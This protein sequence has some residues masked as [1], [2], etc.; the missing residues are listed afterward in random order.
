MGIFTRFSSNAVRPPSLATQALEPRP[1]IP[2]P[3][4]DLALKR[5]LDELKA[6]ER[7]TTAM[8]AAIDKVQAVIEFRL[9]GTVITANDNFLAAV[10]YSLDE[11]R[12]QHHG[13]FVDPVYRASREY[14]EFWTRL[15]SGKHDAGVYCRLGKGGRA[16]WMQASYN[17][18]F[19]PD[20][21]VQSVVKFATDITRQK[22]H[23]ADVAGQIAAIHKS[24]AVIEFNLDGTIITANANF[25][26]AVGYELAEVQGRHHAMFVEPAYRQSHEYRAFWDKLNRGEYD[27][28]EY[29]RLRKDG[30]EIWIQASYNPVTGADGKVY[31]I[32]KYASDVTAQKQLQQMIELVLQDTT[33]AMHNLSGGKLTERM[34][35]TYSGEF[36]KLADA[37]NGYIDRLTAMVRDIKEAASSV[38][39]GAHEIAE[40]NGNLS[41]RTEEQAS[42]LEETSSAVEE[43]TTT[44]QLN[45]ASAKQANALAKQAREAAERGGDTV[46][47]AVVAMQSINGASNKINDIIGVIDEIAFQTNLLALNAAVEAA[48][49]GDQ[50]RG[51]AV[52]ADEVRNLASRSARAAKEIKELIKDSGEKVK[53][54]TT[55]VNTSGS[56]LDDIVN[57]VKK[58]NDIIEEIATASDEQ[59]RGLD[60]V[61]HAISEMDV[62]TQQNAALVEEAAAASVSLGEQAR[63]LDELVAFFDLGAGTQFAPA[64]ARR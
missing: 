29:R 62:T 7:V 18:V 63:M 26:A 40:G 48:R 38:R 49:A 58:V 14:A 22:L 27:A 59:A 45:A 4:V 43:L 13:I 51:F 36:I 47:R 42:S 16:V 31:K 17:P 28:G 5:E 23:D 34:R 60:E 39:G 56:M 10:G 1:V 20:G 3:Q 15:R 8:L 11:V 44:V 25:L 57:S 32:V 50:G 46:R 6:R 2:L 24:Q 61:N 30:R 64:V 35:G 12:G 55:L 21:A 33:I 9:D 53:E 54:G 19:G 52:V 37:I 41:Q